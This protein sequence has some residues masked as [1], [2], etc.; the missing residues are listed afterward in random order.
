VERPERHHKWT[1]GVGSSD[2]QDFADGGIVRGVAGGEFGIVF[3]DQA[4]R[5]M[6]YI[7]GSALIFQIERITQDMG[8]FAPY[9]VISAGSTIY[10]YSNKGFYKIAAGGF[11]E[12]IGRERVDRTFFGDL[13]RANLQLLQGAADPRGT[14]VFWAYKSGAGASGLYDK[15][16]GYDSALERFFPLSASGEY[17]LGISQAGITLENLDAISSSIDALT[18]TLDAYASSVQPQIAQFDSNHKQGFFT[19][20]N[21]E[22][23]LESAEQGTDGQRIFVNGFRPVTDAATL[24]GSCSF[25]ETQQATATAGTEVLISSRTGRCDMRRSTRYS[26]FKVRIPAGTTWTFCAGIEPDISADGET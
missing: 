26:R 13:D 21:L 17:L 24:Y 12:Q 10:F 23:T 11:P 1:S 9:S 6:S 4:I 20:T 14:L 7:P 16:L 22:A 2:F 8:L 25:R 19:G 18:L 3:Q 15:L 5:R